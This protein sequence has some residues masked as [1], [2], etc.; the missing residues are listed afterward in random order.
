MDGKSM[1]SDY[2]F[3]DRVGLDTSNPESRCACILL[4]DTSGSMA[5]QSIVALNDGLHAFK[6][7]LS[8]DS[9][10]LL[11]VEVCIITFGG[12]VSVVQ[13]FI[14]AAKFNPPTLSASGGTPMGSAINVALD[15]L[16]ARKQLYRSAGLTYYRPWIFLITDGAPTDGDVW[17]TS[18]QRIHTLESQKKVAFFCVGV[19]QADM[20]I[21]SQISSRQP[22][23]LRDLNF[24]E[25]FLWL[26][27]SLGA[28]S[29][30]NPGDEVPLQ[31]PSGWANV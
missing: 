14:G 29:R 4:L 23:K 8:Q 13:D 21:L 12:S 11:R 18:A 20:N 19:E 27:N 10:S 5:G 25:M 28:V 31:S 16:D 22:V 9:L 2:G 17:Q 24:R 15:K 7:A 6:S 26:S 1:V 30:S 3:Q